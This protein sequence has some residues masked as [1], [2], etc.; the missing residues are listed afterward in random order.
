MSCSTYRFNVS[1]QCIDSTNQFNVS[2]QRIDSTYRETIGRLTIYDVFSSFDPRGY[3]YVNLRPSMETRGT[4][5]VPEIIEALTD[6]DH[7]KSFL[8]RIS[9]LIGEAKINDRV[10]RGRGHARPL[11]G[12]NACARTYDNV[13]SAT[14]S[15]AMRVG[16]EITI[17][18]SLTFPGSPSVLY[19]DQP[20]EVDDY[21]DLHA[22]PVKTPQSVIDFGDDETFARLR[23]QGK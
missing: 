3:H 11:I 16:K 2:I 21:K 18:H 10:G 14:S 9:E 23:L 8:K 4:I 19:V 20:L 1:I 12:R 5:G 15:T 22:F 13:S 6:L 17:A 7:A